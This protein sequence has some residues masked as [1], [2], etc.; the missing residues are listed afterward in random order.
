MISQAIPLSSQTWRR[1]L[2]RAYVS[3][4]KT[5]DTVHPVPSLEATSDNS[6]NTNWH[7][8]LGSSNVEIL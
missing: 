6:G 5:K 3:E 8:G 7:W 4:T 1:S 2:T